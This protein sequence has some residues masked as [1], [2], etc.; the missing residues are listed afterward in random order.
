[1]IAL[2]LFYFL[3]MFVSLYYTLVMYGKKGI[4]KDFE[5]KAHMIIS[6][7][8]PLVNLAISIYLVFRF[9]KIRD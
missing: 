9:P 7:F 8:V 2:I 3:P 4:F 5:L 6:C 1:M